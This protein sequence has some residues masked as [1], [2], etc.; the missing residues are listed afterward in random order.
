MENTENTTK[1]NA[2]WMEVFEWVQAIVVAVV[3]AMFLRTYVFTL[4]YVD[5]DSMV[6][7]LHNKDR[8]FVWR[9][10]YSAQVDDIIIFRPKLHQDTPY[11]K[12]VIATEGQTIDIVP[13]EGK[14]YCEVYVDGNLVTENFISAKIN[15]THKGDMKYP[16]VV[17]EDH[18]FAMGDNRNFS[19]DSRYKEVGMVSE[20]SIIGKAVFRFFP[21]N[22]IGP[23]S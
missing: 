1:N 15:L 17:P 20:D 21:F 8:L 19:K 4:A 23:L 22:Q 10:G 3:I 14:N 11:V 6:P 13:V 12:R 2:I 9:A 16:A 5:G 7:T 18:V